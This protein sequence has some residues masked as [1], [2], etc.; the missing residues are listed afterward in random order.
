MPEQK[1]KQDGGEGPL[2]AGLS[3]LAYI[4]NPEETEEEKQQWKEIQQRERE[5]LHQKYETEWKEKQEKLS[6]EHPYGPH[7]AEYYGEEF[8]R[9]IVIRFYFQRECVL[10]HV[11]TRTLCRF[12]VGVQEAEGVGRD[13]MESGR[14]GGCVE[15]DDFVRLMD[16]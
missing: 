9:P 4:L 12:R 10:R 7:T 3:T 14:R 11:L 13:V 2:A 16:V 15:A 6:K 5:V 8:R 1:E